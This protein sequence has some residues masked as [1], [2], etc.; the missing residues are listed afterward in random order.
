MN[1][2]KKKKKKKETSFFEYLFVPIQGQDVVIKRHIKT[3]FIFSYFCLDGR[4]ISPFSV[5]EKILL[6]MAI[7]SFSRTPTLPSAV[8]AMDVPEPN[9]GR[10]VC[11]VVTHVTLGTKQQMKGSV[12][13]TSH[14]LLWPFLC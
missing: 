4:I 10:V 7:S 5:E 6:S 1:T 14:C 9:L 12:L 11:Q 2:S 8:A 3:P 13:P